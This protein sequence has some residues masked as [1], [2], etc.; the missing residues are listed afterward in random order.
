MLKLLKRFIKFTINPND[1]IEK[2]CSGSG[3]GG[4][5]VNKSENCVNLL[6]VPTR[7]TVKVHDS[8]DLIINRHIAWKRLT[9]KVEYHLNGDDSKIARRI[10][11]KR[12][13]K[14]R[15]RRK[16]ADKHNNVPKSEE[17]K[18]EDKSEISSDDS[19][20][21]KDEGIKNDKVS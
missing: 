3:P 9:E 2:L 18:E 15:K 16:Y 10:E 11:K 4:Q 21:N 5:K 20:D 19:D 13:N 12:K 14:E 6:H 17:I 8:R 1:V 7:I